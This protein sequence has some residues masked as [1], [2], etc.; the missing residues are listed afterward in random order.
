MVGGRKRYEKFQS[1]VI[2]TSKKVG[3][4][5][6]HVVEYKSSW[7]RID[8]F[9]LE[10]ETASHLEKKLEIVHVVVSECEGVTGCRIHVTVIRRVECWIVNCF[11]YQWYD[12]DLRFLENEQKTN[13]VS[14]A[15][16]FDRYV[17]LFITFYTL[18]RVTF[19]NMGIHF[20]ILWQWHLFITL[21]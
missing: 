20:V 5:H 7:W 15:I 9:S 3:L 21:F 18:F 13:L 14:T 1:C 2:Y 8:Y 16:Y 6:P 12:W 10:V 19:C 11:E 4:S 17:V